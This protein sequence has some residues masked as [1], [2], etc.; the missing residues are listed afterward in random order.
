MFISVVSSVAAP[1]VESAISS[2][3]ENKHVQVTAEQNEAPSYRETEETTEDEGKQEDETEIRSLV[4]EEDMYESAEE[5]GNKEGD[6]K[7]LDKESQKDELDEEE[8]RP[9]TEGKEAVEETLQDSEEDV[10]VKVERELPVGSANRERV[11]SST[12]SEGVSI[13]LLLRVTTHCRV[14]KKKCKYPL[15]VRRLKK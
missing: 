10:K 11:I 1:S 13:I 6:D 8:E 15:K 14:K 9:S 5:E 4:S 12:M 7:D 2:I 3:G